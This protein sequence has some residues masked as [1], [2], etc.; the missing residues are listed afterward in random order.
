MSFFILLFFNSMFLFKIVLID[1]LKAM[2]N[3]IHNFSTSLYHGFY[4]ILLIYFQHCN[5][6]VCS[7]DII[8]IVGSSLFK[9]NHCL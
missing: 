3:N 9:W 1:S 5:I 7:I 8:P 2:R 4:V 6:T